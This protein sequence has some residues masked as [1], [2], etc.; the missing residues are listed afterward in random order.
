MARAGRGA[1]AP[2][3]IRL[4]WEQSACLSNIF[5]R[6]LGQ[7]RSPTPRIREVRCGSDQYGRGK[8]DFKFGCSVSAE[9]AQPPGIRSCNEGGRW[10]LC[11]DS[12][13]AA[14]LVAEREQLRN[15]LAESDWAVTMQELRDKMYRAQ[16]GDLIFRSPWR[17]EHDV[18]FMACT[19]VVLEIKLPTASGAEDDSGEAEIRM[20][21]LYFTEPQQIPEVLVALHLAWKPGGREGLKV[22]DD[23][24]L[25]AQARADEHCDRE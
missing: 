24:A 16:D 22:Q 2:D 10:E 13:G 3:L 25:L 7:R 5:S 17:R 8:H 15:D 4:P 1:G 19:T 20:V 18:D 21:R 23:Q 12:R 14:H 11:R 9:L 6:C